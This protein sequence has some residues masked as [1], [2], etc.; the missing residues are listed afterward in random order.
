MLPPLKTRDMIFTEELIGMIAGVLVI[1]G[2]GIYV[3]FL[4]P[5]V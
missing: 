5:Q 3:S 4:K 2:I 1:S